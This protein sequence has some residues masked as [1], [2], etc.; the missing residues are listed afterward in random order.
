MAT[1]GIAMDPQ[2][3]NINPFPK[4]IGLRFIPYGM[5]PNNTSLNNY[6]RE[7]DFNKLVFPH[8][9][10]LDFN[11]NPLTRPQFR[12]R[13]LVILDSNYIIRKILKF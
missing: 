2:V 4:L 7:E 8:T 12:Y 3:W 1:F 13:Y 11:F 10:K 5:N 9:Y 6:V